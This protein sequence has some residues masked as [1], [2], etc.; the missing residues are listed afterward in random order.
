MARTIDEIRSELQKEFMKSSVAQSLYGL[1][2]DGDTVYDGDTAVTFDTYFSK[3]AIERLIIYIIAFCVNFLERLMDTAEADLTAL[4][5]KQAP[6][7]CDWYARKLKEFQYT[8]DVNDPVQILNEAGEYDVVD[9]TKRVVKHAVAIDDTAVNKTLWLKVAGEN[10]YGHR[11]PLTREQAEKLQYYISQIKYAG[12]PTTLINAEGD[13]F[14]CEV[15]LWYDPIVPE[16]TIRAH[17]EAAIQNYVENLPFNGE[18]SHT[19]FV[20]ALQAVAG[21]KVVGAVNATMTK[22]GEDT[23]QPIGYREV[24]YAGYFKIGAIEINPEPYEPGNI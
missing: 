23:P 22:D 4:V 9:E 6:G 3:V 1:T 19:A 18:Y 10:E 13:R 2:A 20:D 12:V 17:C 16:T 5:E 15:T 21:V 24:P 11:A 14:D 7:R 8:D